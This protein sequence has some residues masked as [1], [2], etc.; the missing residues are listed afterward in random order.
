M[1]VKKVLIVCRFNQARSVVVGAALRKLFP[2]I[3]IVTAGI[4]AGHGKQIPEITSQLCAEW[5][6]PNFDRISIA[7]E[8]L[9]LLEFDAILAVD[10]YVYDCL[11]PDVLEG[12]LYSLY[13]YSDSHSLL[14]IDPTGM[15][16]SEFKTEIAKTMILSLRWIK[17]LNH[18]FESDLDSILFESHSTFL[19][20][21]NSEDSRTY[22]F[23]VD[24]NI[25]IPNQEI[26]ANANF[27][28]KLIDFRSSS[29]GQAKVIDEK[30]PMAIVS[31]F[32]IDIVAEVFLTDRWID[33]LSELSRRGRVA[34]IATLDRS[35]KEKR[36]E[37]L[38]GIV[39]STKSHF[40]EH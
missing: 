10:Q 21:L 29:L 37:A 14:P 9:N 22:E 17:E 5:R 2:E 32:E 36:A 18:Y 6:L 4:E 27:K 3:Q 20:W 12:M 11:K 33:L 23:V 13:Q 25:T 31:K 15:P 40:F 24:T 30:G 1:P 19:T 38:L 35:G 8:R 26:W 39:N 16:P 34:L 28:Y 7:T